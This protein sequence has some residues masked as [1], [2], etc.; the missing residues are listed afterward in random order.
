VDLE[1]GLPEAIYLTLDNLTH[2]QQLDYEQFP[3]K[4][5]VCHEYGHFAKECM[6]KTQGVSNATL[7]QGGERQQV[8]K[9]SPPDR[10][11]G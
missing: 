6:K 9:K 11:E 2:I 10:G 4:Y 1:K 7:E 3:F 5:K 8:K